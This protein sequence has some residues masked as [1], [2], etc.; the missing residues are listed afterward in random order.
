MPCVEFGSSPVRFTL[1][2]T[3]SLICVNVT[4]PITLLFAGCV[5]A[6]FDGWIVATAIFAAHICFHIDFMDDVSFL[7]LVPLSFFIPMPSHPTA[8]PTTENA[9]NKSERW[10]DMRNLPEVVI[11]SYIGK[12]I[13]TTRPL[14]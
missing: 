1:T 4:V 7:L 13:R 12:C 9:T 14:S 11:V 5:V 3:E 10:R 2:F 6:A 8:M